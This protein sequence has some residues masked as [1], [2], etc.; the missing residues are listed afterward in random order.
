MVREALLREGRKRGVT[1]LVAT[2]CERFADVRLAQGRAAQAIGWLERASAH[3][4]TTERH[5][6]S[7]RMRDRLSDA[8]SAFGRH[9][10]A[11]VHH[12]EA[13]RIEARGRSAQAA[14]RA[15]MMAV[16]RSAN[17]CDDELK[18]ASH[19]YRVATLGRMAA[20]IAHEVTQPLTAIRLLAE[21]AIA[22]PVQARE[23]L[24]SIVQR[25]EQ[26]GIYVAHIKRFSRSE[27][28]QMRAV[29]LSCIVDE[30]T[31]QRL[32]S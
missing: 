23:S 24:S 21:S 27:P 19:D 16:D 26:L 30:A 28:V 29:P 14:L 13:R 2:A 22:D 10:Q 3:W 1:W 31:S 5:R 17:P 6:E 11:L 12:K 15:A 25:I 8:Y 7:V 9:A 4:A 18:T 20:S 32:R